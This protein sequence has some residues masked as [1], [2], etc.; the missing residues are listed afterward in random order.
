MQQTHSSELLG[1]A[2][3]DNLKEQLQIKCC[4]TISTYMLSDNVHCDL[5]PTTVKFF[6]SLKAQYPM[7]IIFILEVF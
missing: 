1:S 2:I 5:N 4:N 6:E 7:D 3:Q